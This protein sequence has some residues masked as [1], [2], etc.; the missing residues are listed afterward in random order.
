MGTCGPLWG[1]FPERRGPPCGERVTGVSG[2][3]PEDRWGMMG[4]E[5]VEV[6]S[7]AYGLDWQVLG[8]MMDFRNSPMAF[9][10][11]LRQH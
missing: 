1:C 8:K 7:K 3:G 6:D 4:E 9:H 2:A 11:L 10:G 5:R